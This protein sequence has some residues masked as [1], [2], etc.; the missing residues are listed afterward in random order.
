MSWQR[1]LREIS[2]QKGGDTMNFNPIKGFIILAA[3]ILTIWLL[4]WTFVRPARATFTQQVTI[5]HV[6]GESGNSQTLTLPLVAALNHLTHHDQ[7]YRGECKEPEVTPTPT[8]S[9]TPTPTPEC[10]LEELAE[11]P[12]EVTPTPTATPEA[13]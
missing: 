10:G 12:C 13:T 2:T 11:V 7:D 6:D 1:G 3:V 9:V 5:C 8:E 4:I